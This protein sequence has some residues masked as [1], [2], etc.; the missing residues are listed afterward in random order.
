MEKYHIYWWNPNREHDLTNYV[1]TFPRPD[2]TIQDQIYTLQELMESFTGNTT[3]D[4][5]SELSA[6]TYDIQAE[7]N[8]LSAATIHIQNNI[9]E[10]YSTIIYEQ[11]EI[12]DISGA[13]QWILNE[14]GNFND[15]PYTE[16]TTIYSGATLLSLFRLAPYGA[17]PKDFYT[18][19]LPGYDIPS[20]NPWI[21]TYDENR[22]KLNGVLIED[23]FLKLTVSSYDTLRIEG[24]V[25]F[26]SGTYLTV[27]KNEPPFP[28]IIGGSS[29]YTDS[30]L[31]LCLNDYLTSLGKVFQWYE[32][33]NSTYSMEEKVQDGG[34]PA[35]LKWTGAYYG[36]A[37]NNF[38]GACN[39]IVIDGTDDTVFNEQFNYVGG[40]FV[41][42]LEPLVS[43]DNYRIYPI[44]FGINSTLKLFN[45]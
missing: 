4:I 22:Q 26:S 38:D 39:R 15:T 33:I 18:A 24:Y 14:I 8:V 12:S 44:K 41:V 25:Y 37:V 45:I 34:I 29:E 7:I 21:P 23:S 19:G 31:V 2:L 35:Y 1:P 32:P 30:F 27:P 20:N 6:I 11:G 3:D 17:T 5:I 28:N 40:K 36:H 16:T 42:M 9:D 43:T 13:T 10:V